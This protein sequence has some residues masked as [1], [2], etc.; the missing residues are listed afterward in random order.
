MRA[1]I[2][3]IVA[4]VALGGAAQ[5]A[6]SYA[7]V[8]HTSAALTAYD[9]PGILRHRDVVEFFRLTVWARPEQHHGVTRD[10]MLRH[11]AIDCLLRRAKT[12]ADVLYRMESNAPVLRSNTHGL[13]ESLAPLSVTQHE[14]VL[15][16][17][18]IPS[19]V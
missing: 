6:S 1:V 18:H 12:Y 3:G 7:N 16:Y 14:S 15:R 17:H 4:S 9:A 13:N 19:A 10:Y 5:A 11:I 2:A 8:S